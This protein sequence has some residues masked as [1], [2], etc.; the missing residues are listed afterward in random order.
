M[1]QKI[2]NVLEKMRLE[3]NN[4]KVMLACSTGV[5]SMVLFDLV[6]KLSNINEL[7]IVHINH[8]RRKQSVIEEK[9]IKEY[10]ESLNIKCYINKLPL[11]DGS[12]FQNWARDER[13]KFFEEIALKENADILLLA[14]HANDNLETIIL[15]LI[16]NASL[17]GYAGIRMKSKYHN[18]DIYRP[19]LDL[20]KEDIISYAREN[21]IHYYEDESNE[22]DDYTRNRVRHHIIPVLEKE[23]PSLVKSIQNY[24]NTLFQANDFIENYETN[25]IKNKVIVHNNKEEFYAKFNIEDL[26]NESNFMQEQILF[27]L[28][29]RFSLSKEC[30]KD[31]LKQIFS[32]K[33]NIVQCVNNELSMIKEYGYIIFTNTKQEEKFYLKIEEEGT[34]QL[35]NG[36]LDV[37]KNICNFN[38][39]TSKL[40]YNINSLPIIVRTRKNGDKIV[41]EK[42]TITVSNYLTNHKVP[43]LERN[44]V[45]LL[46]DSNDIPIAI[47][48]YI[49]K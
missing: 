47:L 5:D 1:V 36:T 13:Y 10:C 20:S 27:R 6:R 26:L 30:I 3:L 40:W 25:F 29:K 9:F 8:Q 18:L 23:N 34:Y 15:R 16:R 7:I 28:L 35:I 44:K 24:S 31:T 38:T 43:L 4:K 41:R 48:G 49:I 32:K 45:L 39:S 22:S 2:N 19:L 17:E 42:G 11:Y 12:N 21:N 37:N 33:N 46:C 14:H